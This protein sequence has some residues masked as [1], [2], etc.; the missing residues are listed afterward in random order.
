MPINGAMIAAVVIACPG[1]PI[2]GEIFRKPKTT[3]KAVK[4]TVKATSF[5]E[6]LL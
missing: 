3:Y 2:I 6:S 5:P 1:N 4:Q